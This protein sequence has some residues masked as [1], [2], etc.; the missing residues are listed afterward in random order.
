MKNTNGVLSG[1]AQGAGPDVTPLTEDKVKEYLKRDLS[2]VLHMLDAI[3]RDQDCIDLLA[4][5]MYGKYLNARH[6]AGLESGHP[7]VD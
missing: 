4:Q 3:Y 6:K 5:V 1:T 2:A 7:P